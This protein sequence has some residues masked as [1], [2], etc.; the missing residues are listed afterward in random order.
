MLRIQICAAAALLISLAACEA[1]DSGSAATGQPVL[2]RDEARIVNVDQYFSQYMYGPTLRLYDYG[3]ANVVLALR[4]SNR[5]APVTYTAALHEFAPGTSRKAIAR[6]I[7]NQ[8]S[9]ALYPDAA[10]PMRT[11]NVM[12]S[13]SIRS[14]KLVS[15]SPKPGRSGETYQEYEL[16]FRI[17]PINTQAGLLAGFTD[18]ATVHVIRK[19]F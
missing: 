8:H 4:F 12:T 13:V 7:N 14:E 17:R 2:S 15:D 6:W 19:R 5:Q 10:E 16:T 3:D 1:I 18:K 9:D 11:T